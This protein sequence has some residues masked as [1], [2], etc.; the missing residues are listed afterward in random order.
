MPFQWQN[1][2]WG[3]GLLKRL[4]W[5]KEK[6]LWESSS[7]TISAMFEYLVSFTD[8][9]EVW[10]V[11]MTKKEKDIGPFAVPQRIPDIFMPS[12]IKWS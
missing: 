1:Q 3:L 7:W 8:P 9:T 11:E 5:I 6:M 2:E 12:D 4:Q 10:T